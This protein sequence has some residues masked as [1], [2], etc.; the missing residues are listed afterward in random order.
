MQSKVP[1][2]NTLNIQMKG[3]DYPVLESFQKYIHSLATNL[4]ISVDER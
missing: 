3:Y 2:Y 1:L 4:D